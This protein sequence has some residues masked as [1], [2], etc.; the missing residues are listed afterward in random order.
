VVRY[1]AERLLGIVGV[2]FAV[3]VM[4]FLIMHAV[5]GGPFDATAAGRSQL[6]I[7]EYIRDRLL[8]Q[9]GL[10]Q[11]LAVQY[12]KYMAS[13]LQGDFGVSF[14]TGEPVTAYILRTWPIT[15]II[16][17]ISVVLAVPVGLGLGVLAALHPDTWVDYV[18][19]S[20]VVLT[21]VT[22]TFVV[23]ILLIIIFSVDLQLL[24]TGGWGSP[25]QLIMPVVVYSLGIIGPI[26]RYTRSGMVESLRADYVRTAV[27]KGLTSRTVN[28]RHAFRNASVPLVTLLGPIV[29]NMLVGSFF[30]ETI[31]RI[32]G[33]GAEM[34]VATYNRDYPV[35]MA[36]ALLW[37]FLLAGAYLI[38]DIA[39]TVV[40]PRI[41]FW[42]AS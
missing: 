26:A 16:A 14:N 25:Q 21:F 31:F 5:P 6:P 41:R 13:A 34:T 22:P 10:D 39:Y 30:I 4:I 35:I 8:A 19:S 2:L 11:P 3:S 7:P 33:I 40:D 38:S 28:W 15:M 29:V 23:A 32:P 27:G 37:T 20:L 36:L 1:I 18:T 42:Q 17:A 12:V 9:Y 24:P